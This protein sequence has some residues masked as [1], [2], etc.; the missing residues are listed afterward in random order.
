MKFLKLI[1][2]AVT[3]CFTSAM[4]GQ[5]QRSNKKFKSTQTLKKELQFTTASIENILVVDNVYGSIDVE[6]H[7]GSTVLIEATRTVYADNEEDLKKGETEIGIKSSKRGNAIY[8]H[9]DSPYSHFDIEIGNFEY[10]EFNFNNRRSYKHR[11]KRMYKYVL[12][13]KIKIPKKTSVDLKAINKGDIT[14]ENVHG[15]LLIAHNINGAISLKNV[16]GKTDVNALNKNIDI[17]YANNPKEESWYRSLN[18]D[19]TI[20]FKNNLNATISYK[21]LNGKFFTNFDVEKTLTK[22]NK[23]KN[24]KRKKVKYKIDSNSHFKIGKGN[25]HLHFNQLNGDAIVKK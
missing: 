9:L 8:V 23:I 1:T 24:S 14:V 18:G 5:K 6:G 17:T 3:L 20:K 16:S 2:I 4:L 11:T 15:K 25:V 13:F 7:N 19:I 10:R 21:T 12:N 22:I